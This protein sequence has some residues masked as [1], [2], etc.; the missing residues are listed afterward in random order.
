MPLSN[1]EAQLLGRIDT[2]LNLLRQDLLGGP[3]VKGKIPE[4]NERLLTLEAEKQQRD[5]AIH[6]LKWL[7]GIVVLLAGWFGIHVAKGH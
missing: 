3:G 5:G 6:T 7:W 4:H 2:N 1:E